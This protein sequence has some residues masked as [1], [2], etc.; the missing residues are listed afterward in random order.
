MESLKKS[1][2]LI[3][4]FIIVFIFFVYNTFFASK[5]NVSVGVNTDIA[6]EENLLVGNEFLDYLAKV[7]AIQID[8]SLFKSTAWTNLKDF[9]KPLPEVSPGKEDL[10]G[11]SLQVK[12]QTETVT[13]KNKKR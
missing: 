12:T 5:N 13:D 10:F 2:K 8:D 3:F 1:N 6:T 9:G 11:L 7:K 4:V